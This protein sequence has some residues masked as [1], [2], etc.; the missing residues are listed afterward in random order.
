MSVREEIQRRVPCETETLEIDYSQG[1]SR[2]ALNSEAN[3]KTW[4]RFSH[5]L[6]KEEGPTI[7]LISDTWPPELCSHQFLMCVGSF[8]ITALGN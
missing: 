4:N 7:T 3:K 2:T 6:Q 8:V 5:S 1:M